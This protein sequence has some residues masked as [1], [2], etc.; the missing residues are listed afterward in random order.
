MPLA[1]GQQLHLFWDG[2]E[3]WAVGEFPESMSLAALLL[4]EYAKRQQGDNR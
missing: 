1:K 2:N 3:A 4:L